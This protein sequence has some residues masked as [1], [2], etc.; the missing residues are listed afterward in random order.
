MQQALIV[1]PFDIE[2]MAQQL[3]VALTM[4]LAE[5]IERHAALLEHVLRNDA[6]TWLETFLTTLG[7]GSTSHASNEEGSDLP[8]PLPGF[9]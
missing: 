3:Y 9:G 7:A 6:R 4:P 2:D 1:N 8:A 5:R